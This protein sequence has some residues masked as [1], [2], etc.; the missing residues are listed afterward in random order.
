MKCL[1]PIA[2]I[3]AGSLLLAGYGYQSEAD[4]KREIC[5]QYAAYPFPSDEK[6]NDFY[7][8]LGI[9]YPMPEA[10]TTA[11]PGTEERLNVVGA[12]ATKITLI[13][14]FCSYYRS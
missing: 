1:T 4:R 7:K 5:A 3:A 14:N 10:D 2:A 8:R 13:G 11:P 9:E 12:R 6:L